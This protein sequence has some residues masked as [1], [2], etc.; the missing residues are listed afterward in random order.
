MIEDANKKWLGVGDIRAVIR[1]RIEDK[2]PEGMYICKYVCIFAWLKNLFSGTKSYFYYF[3]QRRKKKS[4][5]KRNGRK[6][7]LIPEKLEE[8][9]SI[10]WIFFS[11]VFLSRLDLEVSKILYTNF[12]YTANTYI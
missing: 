4:N 5:L 6:N 1:K 8:P 9:G 7:K 12:I 3:V 11:P 2:S 10:P